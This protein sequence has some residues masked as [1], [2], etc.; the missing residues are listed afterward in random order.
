MYGGGSPLPILLAPSSHPSATMPANL[1]PPS[2]RGLP[3]SQ[4]R[5]CLAFPAFVDQRS[6]L[7]PPHFAESSPCPQGRGCEKQEI[8]T[9]RSQGEFFCLFLCFPPSNLSRSDWKLARRKKVSVFGTHFFLQSNFSSLKF[10]AVFCALFK[11][12]ISQNS[13]KVFSGIQLKKIPFSIW[14]VN[15][16]N[17]VKLPFF[18]IYL[19]L[20]SVLCLFSACP[21]SS[22]SVLAFICG[23][24]TIARIQIA[25]KFILGRPSCL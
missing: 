16:V 23:Q 14:T 20:V 24:P 2:D 12:P 5:A 17:I 11:A 6:S 13:K 3:R 22:N 18:Y 15:I 19:H 1:S 25:R 10:W 4:A 8:N 21:F 9:V 7:I